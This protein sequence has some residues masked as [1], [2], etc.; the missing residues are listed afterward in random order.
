M[1]E[2]LVIVTDGVI[3]IVGVTDGEDVTIGVVVILDVIDIVGVF[4]G[5]TE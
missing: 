3:L 2:V 5:V 1:V 4:V